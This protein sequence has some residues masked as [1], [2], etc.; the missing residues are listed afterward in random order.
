M[1]V[2]FEENLENLKKDMANTSLKFTSDVFSKHKEYIERAEVRLKKWEEDLQEREIKIEVKEKQLE[3][4]EE[5]NLFINFMS[6]IRR[7]CTK[8]YC[9]VLHRVWTL[10][11]KLG[12]PWLLGLQSIKKVLNQECLCLI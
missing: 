10:F 2:D 9:W 7:I 8:F 4:R 6:W 12:L 1:N 5:V 11:A 3:I